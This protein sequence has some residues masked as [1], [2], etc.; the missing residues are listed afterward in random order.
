M[1]L[2]YAFFGLLALA[3]AI[4]SIAAYLRLEQNH[5]EFRS[6][7]R[8]T[9][10]DKCEIEQVTWQG[11]SGVSVKLRNGDWVQ[12]PSLSENNQGLTNSVRAWLVK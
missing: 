12:L 4:E 5:L 7:F 1:F 8:R 3:A 2:F 6:N 11:G 9:R 10:I